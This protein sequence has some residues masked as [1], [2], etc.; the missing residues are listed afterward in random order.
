MSDRR[1]MKGMR[2]TPLK[3]FKSVD[4][5]LAVGKFL[6]DV[7]LGK[8]AGES[9]TGTAGG[10]L[11]PVELQQ[12]IINLREVAGTFRNSASVVPM[13]SDTSS[14]PRRTSGV[15]AYYVDE[16]GQV[17][18]S[19]MG[20]GQVTLR[21]KKLAALTR[22][23][24]ELEDDALVSLADQL[25]SEMSYAFAAKE[26]AAGWNGDGTSTYKGIV[27]VCPKIL[28]GNHGASKITAAAG[29]DTFAEI[30]ATDLST[31]MA[32]LPSYA[33]P[34]ARWFI[35]GP[36]AALVFYRLAGDN[37]G[38]GTRAVNGQPVPSFWNMPIMATPALPT[39]Q[40]S[41]TGSVMLAL[42]DLSLAALLGDRLGVRVKRTES[43][44][45]ESDEIGWRGVE[46][47]D[48]NV[49]DLGDNTTA[50]PIVGLVGA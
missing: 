35:S 17:T 1:L 26:D 31:L 8:A 16:Q 13:G 2:R 27:G 28:D 25:A 30:D 15:T 5:A 37:G 43:R 47:Y 38:I 49:H 9:D 32:A 21:T 22:S 12:A 41:L 3:A 34:N 46:R 40:T 24:S 6:R 11:V 50:G 29:H 44:Y 23:S 14:I 48:I 19:E 10:Y 4:D 45:I 42:G 20:W 33:L 39:A 18:E 7:A 36:G